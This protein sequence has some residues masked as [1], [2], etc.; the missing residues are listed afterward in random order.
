MRGLVSSAK[1]ASLSR[2]ASGVPATGTSVVA[3][4]TNSFMKLML[5]P[6]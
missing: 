6:F 4:S 3:S 5:L 2:S 1:A